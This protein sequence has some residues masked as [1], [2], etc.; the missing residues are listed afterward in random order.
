MAEP[1]STQRHF[2]RVAEDLLAYG[3][4]SGLSRVGGLVLLPILTRALSVDEY[5]A[6]DVVA[7]LVAFLSVLLQVA[8]PAALARHYG[9]D[10]ARQASLVSTLV[11]FLTALGLLLLPC[12][13]LLADG[14]GRLLLG[15]SQAGDFVRLGAG[16]AWLTSLLAVLHTV[17]R[18]QRRIVAFN[19][20]ELARTLAY[21]GLAVLLV[22]GRRQ[23]VIGV[24]QAQ[25]LANALVLAATLV[26]VRRHLGA[27][28]SRESLRT[29]LSFGAPLLPGQL[30]LWVNA[31]T[32]RLLLLAFVGLAGV[33]LFGVS[34]R[35]VTAVQFLLLV[36]RQAW[37]PHAMRLI[38]D[39]AR[40][41]VYRRML[42]YFGGGFALLCLW[43]SALGPEIFA[44]AVPAG[45]RASYVVLPWLLGASVLHHSASLTNLGLV[46]TGETAAISGA[47]F[48]A[49]AL[50]VALALALIPSFGI[51][52]AAVGAFAAE[53]V[54]TGLLLRLS[55]R[56]A[57][58]HFD[59]RGALGMVAAYA[60][61]CAGMLAAW[62]MLEGSASLGTRTALALVA[63]LWISRCL[64]RAP[65]VSTYPL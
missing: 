54:F 26:L 13:H 60:L 46:A 18:M 48:A 6:V 65:A 55:A 40:G 39:P 53:L 3:L 61:A 19:L 16:V 38:D 10:P 33:G 57:Q 64:P 1:A 45:F 20:L 12:V 58:L 62:Q 36:F 25:L 8:L 9:D 43:L 32:D 30:V 63:T 4:L 41:E 14:L 11:W 22:V 7:A 44:V 59:G 50:N 31:Q 47:S 49:V 56:R 2:Q 52:G 35:I 17:L 21:V 34:A 37:Q 5:G 24:F 42:G 51:A 28:P 15:G 23:G 29:L 27:R